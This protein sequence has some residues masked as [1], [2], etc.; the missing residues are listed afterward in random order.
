MATTQTDIE[1][2]IAK[3]N[4]VYFY[5]QGDSNAQGLL[6]Q[7]NWNFKFASGALTTE[8]WPLVMEQS[9]AKQGIKTIVENHSETG[10]RLVG[11]TPFAAE[12]PGVGAKDGRVALQ[13]IVV[14]IFNKHRNNNAPVYIIINLGANDLQDQS[15]SKEYLQNSLIKHVL[16]ILTNANVQYDLANK[17]KDH[18]EKL[19][20]IDF[21]E[22]LSQF[23]SKD[24]AKS[25]LP[26]YLDSP[27][28]D[29]AFSKLVAENLDIIKT[30]FTLLKWNIA[31]IPPAR[32]IGHPYGGFVHA[33]LSME[34]PNIVEAVVTQIGVKNVFSIKNA[35]TYCTPSQ[36]EFG[37]SIHFTPEDHRRYGQ[38]IALFFEQKIRL[39]K[40]EQEFEN[41]QTLEQATISATQYLTNTSLA[42]SYHPAAMLTNSNALSKG[43]DLATRQDLEPY[44]SSSPMILGSQEALWF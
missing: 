22:H 2:L 12:V 34:W 37:G 8:P 10:R 4:P 39:Q 19:R 24:I 14:N 21:L 38:Q 40:L 28:H 20:M 31:I 17:I 11:R 7:N 42:T 33:G 30:L 35:Q 26:T 27:M 25:Y 23:M 16:T 3:E 5:I 29:E 36:D 44:E 43:T 32:I 15:I 18:I 13:Q 9:L 41:K 6:P 1:Q